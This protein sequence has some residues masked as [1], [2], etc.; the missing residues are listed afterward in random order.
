M[1]PSKLLA[2][3]SHRT[4][5]DRCSGWMPNFFL[6]NGS[7]GKNK[8]KHDFPMT[9]RLTEVRKVI[10]KGNARRYGLRP[11]GRRNALG[12]LLTKRRGAWLSG[13]APSMAIAFRCNTH[14]APNYRVPPTAVT[15]DPECQ[16]NCLDKD[17]L[18]MLLNMLTSQESS[19]P[20]RMHSRSQCAWH[21]CR[22]QKEA[23]C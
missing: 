20:L 12:S 19:P 8:C 5:G 22:T 15:H 9:K 4:K 23:C 21:S 10:C 7:Q 11:S 3:C 2:G 17:V 18:S 16:R 13:C 1:L 14:T 6:R